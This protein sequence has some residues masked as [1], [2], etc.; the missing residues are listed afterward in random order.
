MK[1][2]ILVFA[3]DAAL[4][5][6]SFSLL[7]LL[8]YLVT[9]YR[10]EM[11]VLL[12]YRGKMEKRLL[13]MK[14]RFQILNFPHCIIRREEISFIERFK[15]II[16][17]YRRNERIA[18]KLKQIVQEFRPDLI[19]TNTSIVSTGLKI[20]Q[21]FNLPHIWHVRE[22]GVEDFKYRYLPSQ[23]YHKRLI[24]HSERVI[25]I[26]KDLRKYWVNS[27]SPKYNVVYNGVADSKIDKPFPKMIDSEPPPAA[28]T[29]TSPAR[30]ATTP[31]QNKMQSIVS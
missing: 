28:A 20:A 23:R 30:S 16:N 31:S 29:P 26:S 8:E 11:M 12:P 27:E 3:H 2:K 14:I 19:Y 7:T 24:E 21:K 1:N 13:N 9:D 10:F 17:F 4:Y 18:K 15:A 22:Y 25:F 6:A 5:G